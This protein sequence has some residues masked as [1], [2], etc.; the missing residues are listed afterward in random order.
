MQS[1][2]LYGLIAIGVISAG[3]LGFANTL[4]VSGLNPLGGSDGDVLSP[5]GEIT[6][7]AWTEIAATT[8]FGDIAIGSSQVTVFNTDG[9]G[10]DHTYEVCSRLSDNTD[11]IASIVGCT[12][13][14]LI[15]GGGSGEEIVSTTYSPAFDPIE[16]KNIYITLEQI[17]P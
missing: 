15:A 16:A 5:N 2:I 10:F 1:N 3:T 8:G 11:T 17:D 7:V 9:V 12:T 6:R 14:G 4:T 13:T